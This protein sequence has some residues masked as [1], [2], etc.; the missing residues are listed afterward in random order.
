MEFA[1]IIQA[2]TGSKRFPQKVL[3]NINE[4][5]NVLDFLIKRILKKFNKKNL[6]IATTRLKEDL[7]ICSIAKKNKIKYFTG[8]KK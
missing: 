3:K 2:R 4:D 7:G 6:I 1:I 8:S 5:T